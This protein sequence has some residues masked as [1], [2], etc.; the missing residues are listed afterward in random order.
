MPGYDDDFY[1][2]DEYDNSLRG[3]YPSEAVLARQAAAH[4][5][6]SLT[7]QDPTDRLSASELQSRILLLEDLAR[8]YRA[9]LQRRP[10]HCR[11][12]PLLKPTSS[13]ST[14]CLLLQLSPDELGKVAHELCDPLRPRYAVHLSST[15]KGLRAPMQAAL[16]WLYW[17]RRA[18][19]A[20][21]AHLGERRAPEL[22]NGPMR[23]FRGTSSGAISLSELELGSGYNNPL[24]RDARPPL[25]LDHWKTLGTL[26]GCGSFPHLTRLAIKGIGTR[27]DQHPRWSVPIPLLVR[28]PCEF[29]RVYD[30]AVRPSEVVALLAA[31]L[32]R[33]GLPSL[34]YLEIS[35]TQIGDQ[36]ASVLSSALTKRAVPKLTSIHLSQN[37]LGDSGLSIMASALR[38]LPKLKRIILDG[39]QIGDG[40]LAT[41]LG[42]PMAGVFGSLKYLHVGGESNNVS[43]AGRALL[44]VLPG[45][46]TQEVQSWPNNDRTLLWMHRRSGEKLTWEIDWQKEFPGDHVG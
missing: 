25:T 34:L 37:Q 43:D 29:A 33:G 30:D 24:T 8:A 17:Q 19:N 35:Q 39:N 40:G 46:S 1:T 3:W 6:T 22:S 11:E 9:E 32:R 2:Y 36:A 45:G 38:R 44:S 21:A 26:V 42:E 18:A 20:L 16:Y 13:S 28:Y 4:F 27:A 15:A 31:G 10:S 41:L 23:R 12:V 5:A 14:C 7:M